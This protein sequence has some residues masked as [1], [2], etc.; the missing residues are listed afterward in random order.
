MPIQL[1][2]GEALLTEALQG[3]GGPGDMK[4]TY[5]TRLPGITFRT[6]KE[7]KWVQGHMKVRRL[8]PERMILLLLSIGGPLLHLTFRLRHMTKR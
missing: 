5:G 7:D 6:R 4:L 3:T 1:R 8:L 2:R